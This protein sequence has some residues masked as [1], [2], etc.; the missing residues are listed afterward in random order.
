MTTVLPIHPLDLAKLRTEIAIIVSVKIWDYLDEDIAWLTA[1]VNDITTQWMTR[2]PSEARITPRIG[3]ERFVDDYILAVQYDPNGKHHPRFWPSSA[4]I[5]EDTYRLRVWRAH[6]EQLLRD[7]P[8][9]DTNPIAVPLRADA[10]SHPD[11]QLRDALFT[12][13]LRT[14]VALQISGCLVDPLNHHRGWITTVINDV[15]TR[16]QT[17]SGDGG[18]PQTLTGPSGFADAYVG[19]IEKELG[20]E[21]YRDYFKQPKRP[22]D[23]TVYTRLIWQRHVRRLAGPQ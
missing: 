22:F 15:V 23:D 5:A 7:Q 13:R 10:H 8:T 17:R 20:R 3:L 11:A 4:P 12:E 1:I 21:I 19:Q 6:A 18:G 9:A 16:W 2:N 14:E